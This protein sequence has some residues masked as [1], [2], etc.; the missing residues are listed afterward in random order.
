MTAL[1]VL[2]ADPRADR[3]A[4]TAARLSSAEIKIEVKIEVLPPACDAAAADA[5]TRSLRPS[6]M[7]LA[8]D[9]PP[10]GGFAACETLARLTPILLLS[11][12]TRPDTLR[13][14]MR[15]GARDV[16]PWT[17]PPDDFAAALRA[18]PIPDAP[19]LPA[20]SARIIAIAGAKGGVGR[21]TL[22]VNLAA[23]LARDTGEPTA[24]LDLHTQF[25][26]A[27]LMLGLTPRRTLADWAALAPDTLDARFLEDY[28]DR[29]DS[30]LL[31]LAGAAA[32]LAPDAL[33]PETV[34]RVLTLLERA[35][36]CIVLD[37]PPLI[38][39]PALAALARADDVLLVADLFD[40]PTLAASR[41]W[42][43]ALCG[44]HLAS[45]AVRVVFSRVVP[46]SRLSVSDGEQVL[47]LTAGAII[48]N[49][50]KLVPASVNAGVPFVLSHPGSAPAKSIA[51]L[52]RTLSAGTGLA[53]APRA[54]LPLFGRKPALKTP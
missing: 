52:A 40:L 48:P 35:C 28:A 50:G 5:L 8:D 44:P 15:A 49:D 31:L 20:R 14:A 36:R 34:D 42:L 2:L 24:L 21:T 25:A 18:I 23:A 26:N 6:V 33:S 51:A 38:D 53:A 54:R 10:G 29:H 9:L 11:D 1:R 16:L 32:P 4:A 27:A 17:L 43:D 22:A 41:R 3:R 7:L 13:R 47:G 12:D 30:G 45:D 37:L 46:R 39:G 19:S